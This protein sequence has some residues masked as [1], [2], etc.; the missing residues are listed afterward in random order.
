MK[1]I[2]EEPCIII[3]RKLIVADLHLGIESKFYKDG[4]KMPSQ[5]KAV[6]EKIRRLV[7]E[8]ELSEVIFIGDIK[9]EVPG[10]SFQEQREIPEFMDSVKKSA[11]VRVLSGNHDGD[12]ERMLGNKIK[13]EK[14]IKTRNIYLTHGHIWPDRKFLECK[15]IIIGHEHPQ[16]EFR[17][18]LGYRFTEQVWI[19]AKLSWP[20]ISKQYRLKK[21]IM[22]PELVIMPAF[23]RFSGGISLNGRYAKTKRTGNAI[24]LGPIAR[25]ANM[26][27][28]DIYLLDGTHLGKLK[29]L[30]QEK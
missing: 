30:V 28:S 14:E 22:L 7:E 1:F 15:T 19:R 10:T 9:H 24:G 2:N 20:K 4:I 11:K 17:D 26:R 21:K 29:D 13:I 6:A 25:S 18:A 23:N 8:Y 16:I 5:T 27:S 12:I 3:G